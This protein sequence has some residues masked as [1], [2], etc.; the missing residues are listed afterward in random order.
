MD[1]TTLLTEQNLET[2]SRAAGVSTK[3]VSSIASSLLPTLLSNMGSNAQSASGATSLFNALLSHAN[4]DNTKVDENDGTKILG[5]ILGMNQQATNQEVAKKTGLDAKTVAKVAALLAPILLSTLGKKAQTAQS[6]ANT[7]ASALSM[8]G[9]G[10]S[11]Q[12]ASS[13][14]DASTM[15][16]LLGKLLK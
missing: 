12:T 16:S 9:L 2:I 4:D 6:T 13:G 1:Y 7:A 5:H 15:I 8:F 11:N 14:L 10:N 3:D